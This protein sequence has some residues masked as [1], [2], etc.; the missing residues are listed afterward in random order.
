MK[1]IAFLLCLAST[2]HAY[3][4]P[5][6]PEEVEFETE[7]VRAL[8]RE[9][10][11]SLSIEQLSNFVMDQYW[12]GNYD[13]DFHYNGANPTKLSAADAEK[14]ANI[15]IH[16]RD[17]NQGE[18]LP[19]LHYFQHRNLGPCFTINYDKSNF[20]KKLRAKMKEIKDLYAAAGKDRVHIHL[21]GHAEGATN[22]VDFGFS[23]EKWPKGVRISK[24][25]AVAGR[26]KNLPNPLETPY[27]AFAYDTL[28]RLDAIWRNVKKRQGGAVLYTIAASDDWLIPRESIDLGIT[29]KRA[30]I[31]GKGHVLVIFATETF[32]ILEEFVKQP[33]TLRNF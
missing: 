5:P 13:E 7:Q 4:P 32:R 22:A 10:I 27:Y 2:A 15:F 25:I 8:A 20:S 6:T 19:V 3:L 23:P 33:D 18:F 14:S 30:L 12:K 21:I 1:I 24:V 9:E 11:F 28:V 17:T 16:A 26:V 31:A 29:G